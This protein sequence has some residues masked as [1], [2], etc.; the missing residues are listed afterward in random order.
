MHVLPLT[1]VC[2]LTTAQIAAADEVARFA[3]TD[4]VVAP[5]GDG[6]SATIGINGAGARLMTGGGFEPVAYRTRMTAAADAPLDAPDRIAIAP[7]EISAW[8]TLRDGALDGAEVSVYRITDGL[9]EEVRRSVVAPGGFHVSGWM[10]QDGP[11]VDIGRGRAQVRIDDWERPGVP[12][13]YALR[14]VDEQGRLSGWSAPQRIDLPQVLA[15]HPDPSSGTRPAPFKGDP[16]AEPDGTGP[17]RPTDVVAELTATGEVVLTWADTPDAAATLVYASH[18]APEEMVGFQIDLAPDGGVPVRAGDMLILRKT[19]TAPR[20]AEVLANRI[21]NAGAARWISPGFELDPDRSDVDWRLDPHPADP[22]RDWGGQTYLTVDLPARSRLRLGTHN[23]AGTAQ[24]WYDVLDPDVTY[25][26]QARLRGE[27]RGRATFRLRGHYEDSVPPVTLDYGTDWTLVTGRFRVPDLQTERDPIGRMELTLQGPGRVDLDDLRVWP[28]GSVWLEPSPPELAILRDAGVAALRTHDL[29]K[30]SSRT[31]DLAALT[32]S[33]GL[34]LDDRQARGLSETL[35]M[36]D[37]VGTA[38]WLQLEPHLSG[39]EWLGLVEY[40][41]APFDPARDD[42]AALPHAARRVAQG[43]TAPWTDAFDRIW[44]EIGNETWNGMFAPWTF[45]GMTDAATGE[46]LEAATVYGLYQ[47][48]V[49]R[50]LRASPWWASA[51]LNDKVRFVIGG[52]AINDYGGKAARAAGP[53]AAHLVTIAAYNGGWDEGEGPARDTPEGFRRLMAQ[54]QQVTVPRTNTLAERT[55]AAGPHLS[56]GSYEAGPGFALNGLNGE[57]VTP[58]QVAAQERVMRSRAAG[59]A[60]LDTFLTQRLL[61]MTMQNYFMFQ[62]G[63]YWASHAPWHR[64]GAPYASWRLTMLLNGAASGEMLQV[65]DRGGV[66]VADFPA[67]DSREAVEGAPQVAVFASRRAERLTV[68]ALSRRVPDGP[69]VAC[70]PVEIALPDDL[71]PVTA[72]RLTRTGGQFDD[73]DARG[74]TPTVI[75]TLDLEPGLISPDRILRLSPATGA[76]ACGLPGASAYVYE[77][78]LGPAQ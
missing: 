56:F 38:P 51:G 42:P 67:S 15:R 18:V 62:P 28:E 70:T 3:V 73:T 76:E 10:L 69:D 17:D 23:H 59:V 72:L 32:G 71:P 39:D 35:R 36:M 74:G 40:L 45:P 34:M 61:G 63:S 41:A 11:N 75:E 52:W 65:T 68:T 2:L 29:I 43:R 12:R 47:A 46:A 1:L 27:R 20:R 7:H 78:S 58:E 6:V 8:D 5:A 33:G 9:M 16:L 48:M 25:L 26:V 22:A 31:Y 77:L 54:S 19:F 64:G 37:K 14:H 4:Q 49:V 55:T 44:L 21:W 66:P 50:T 13:W 57:R 30:T 60:T 53:D 24:D